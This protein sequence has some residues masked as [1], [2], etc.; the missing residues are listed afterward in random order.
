MG[1]EF[2]AVN[3]MRVFPWLD[4]AALLLQGEQKRVSGLD[5]AR[6]KPF[7]QPSRDHRRLSQINPLGRLTT[8]C[9]WC[10][11]IRNREGLWQR[12]RARRACAA[13]KLSH[14]I[15]PEC[16]DR[17]YNAYRDEKLGRNTAAPLMSNH[18]DSGILSGRRAAAAA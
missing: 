8:I 2:A 7:E 1:Q 13:V 18:F 11:K 5:G 3:R 4:A 15:C 17:T 6:W 16:A 10:R 12:P 9:A 14:G